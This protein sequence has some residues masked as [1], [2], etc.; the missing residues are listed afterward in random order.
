MLGA[1]VFSCLSFVAGDLRP[2]LTPSLSSLAWHSGAGARVSDSQLKEPGFE[3]CAAM[4]NLGQDHP[5]YPSPVHSV[6]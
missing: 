1:L 2:V 4:F 5:I 3:S 6:V